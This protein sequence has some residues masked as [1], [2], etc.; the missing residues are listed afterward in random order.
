LQENSKNKLTFNIWLQSFESAKLC[1]GNQGLGN[2]SKWLNQK[3]NTGTPRRM[4]RE[5]YAAIKLEKSSDNRTGGG[6]TRLSSMR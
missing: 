4:L 5:C 1:R 6:C 3:G 2:K